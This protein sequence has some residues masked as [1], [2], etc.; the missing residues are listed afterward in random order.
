MTRVHKVITQNKKT[1]TKKI[2]LFCFDFQKRNKGS[3]KE[4]GPGSR[5]KGVRLQK[6]LHIPAKSGIV[7]ELP[8]RKHMIF[9]ILSLFSA[10]H[11]RF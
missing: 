10:V 4:S 3:W 6:R 1:C 7:G 11:T 9:V 2:P 8:A 5:L